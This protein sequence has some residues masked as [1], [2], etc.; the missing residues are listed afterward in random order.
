M[1]ELKKRVI[2]GLCAAPVIAFLFYILP[3]FWFLLLLAV[4]CAVAVY[5]AARLVRVSMGLLVAVLVILG[6]APLYLRFFQIYMLWVMALVCILIVIRV[7]ARKTPAE[8][9]N[10]DLIASSAIVLFGNF[11]I[12]LPFFYIYLLKELDNLFPLILLFSIWASDIAAYFIGKNL[13][14]HPLA[15]QISPKK[16]IEGLFGSVLGSMVIAAASFQLL[17]V[18]MARA[19]IIGAVI[20]ILGQAGDLLESS[21][22]RVL[23]TKDSSSLLPGH[24]GLLDRIDS[25]TFTAPFLY[26]CL[27][28][29]R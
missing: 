5:E 22:K 29:T 18:T 27:V 13:G 17:G 26:I 1:G 25:F 19:L 10:R 20:G 9:A 21:C 15:P 11:F 14:K 3:Q 23:D 4:A 6:L 28:W 2:T 8:A 12:V 24:G 16:T 7:F